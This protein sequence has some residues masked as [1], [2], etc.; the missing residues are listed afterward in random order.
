MST[1]LPFIVQQQQRGGQLV[2]SSNPEQYAS[3]EVLID[4]DPPGTGTGGTYLDVT[5]Q[6][7]HGV[8]SVSIRRGRDDALLGMSAGTATIVLH[9]PDGLYNPENAASPLFGELL[10]MRSVRIAADNDGTGAVPL[11]GGFIRSIDHDPRVGA[12]ETVIECIDMFVGLDQTKPIFSYSI[13]VTTVTTGEYIED[14]VQQYGSP[15]V[16]QAGLAQFDTGSTVAAINP[17]GDKSVLQLIEDVLAVDR[18][19]FYCMADGAPRYE[20]TTTRTSKTSSATI[21]DTMLATRPGVDLDRI[22]NRARVTRTGGETQQADDATSQGLYGV[23]DIGDIES[24]YLADDADAL[25]LATYLVGQLK[26]PRSPMYGLDLMNRDPSTMT[27]ILNRELQDRITVVDSRGGTSGDYH[28]EAIE[29]QISDGGK[30]HRCRWVLSAR[31]SGSQT[32]HAGVIGAGVTDNPPVPVIESGDPIPA[33][34]KDGATMF[35]V[36]DATNGVVWQFRYDQAAAEWRF[37][38]GPPLVARVDTDQSTAS[39]TYTATG[40]TSLS[41]TAPLAGDYLIRGN[42]NTYNSGVATNLM[43]YQVGASAAS[44]TNAGQVAIAAANYSAMIPFEN[45]HTGVAASTAFS[46]RYRTTAGTAN[47]RYRWLALIPVRVSA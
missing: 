10:P 9:D 31:G 47:F 15:W 18:G 25:T 3:Y 33:T 30:F 5:A 17:S 42:A 7:G 35:Y 8:K 34:A 13:G 20:A 2:V 26:D 24:P 6:P 39:G 40:F 12:R 22:G 1:L 19:V 38:G 14:L 37:V 27:Q 45:R 11:F 16:I 4:W 23:R 28:I 43:S 44:D 32:G 21:N 29:H 41:V 46:A 36:A